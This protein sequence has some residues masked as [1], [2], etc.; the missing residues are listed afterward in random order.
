[1]GIIRSEEGLREGLKCI[2]ELREKMKQVGIAGGT[3]YNI[4]WNDW[5]NLR[6]LLDASEMI[7]LSSLERRE[8]RGAHYRSD[9][10][11]KNNK[12]YL[13]NF[14][15][16]RKN[17]ETKIFERPVVMNRLKPEDIKFE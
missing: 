4:P 8:S 1:L 17:G 5:L 15:L 10:P 2:H 6:N 3:A 9:Y 16:Q 11:K 7:G 12:E 13:K 14:F